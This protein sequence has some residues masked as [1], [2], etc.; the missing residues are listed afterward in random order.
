MHIH[1]SHMVC[2]SGLRENCKKLAGHRLCW[3]H[4]YSFWVLSYSFELT[5][6]NTAA[7]KKSKGSWL[8]P[9]Q[10]EYGDSSGELAK[11]KSVCASMCVH[12]PFIK[13]SNLLKFLHFKKLQIKR[14]F[15][16]QHQE[17]VTTIYIHIHISFIQMVL[18]TVSCNLMHF[19]AC[20]LQ[21][22]DPGY[23]N[24]IHTCNCLI[25]AQVNVFKAN[26]LAS[27]FPLLLIICSL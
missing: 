18:H 19:S 12:K 6:H 10:M 27:N 26:T 2:I 15:T 17:K 21:R 22:D 8:E 4:Y 24:Y 13:L 23:D 1:L 7:Q 25:R 5:N 3:H 9:C 16:C 11:K 14:T 20:E